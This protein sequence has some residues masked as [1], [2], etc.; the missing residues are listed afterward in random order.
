[1]SE[2]ALVLQAAMTAFAHET[3][4]VSLEGFAASIRAK[5]PTA[6]VLLLGRAQALRAAEASPEAAPTPVPTNAPAPLGAFGSPAV[7]PGPPKPTTYE[8]QA[9][10]TPTHIAERL[11]HDAN[12]WPDLVAANPE[13]PTTPDGTFASL[14]PGETLNLPP[15]WSAR[16]MVHR[17]ASAPS[18]EVHS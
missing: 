17:P 1:M 9:G 3:D 7:A 12:R 13:K 8:V 14:R 18:P 2:P 15:S 10:D 5:Y 6:T 4:P 11:T 16:P